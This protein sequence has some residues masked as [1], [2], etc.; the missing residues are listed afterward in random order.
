[1]ALDVDGDGRADRLGRDTALAFDYRTG[2]VAVV[3]PGPRGV[4]DVG[5]LSETSA[6]W[7]ARGE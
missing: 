6:G 5:R 4:G 2:V 3:P 1:M 7:A